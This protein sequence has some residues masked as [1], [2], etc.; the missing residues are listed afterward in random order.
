[1]TLLDAG[2]GEGSFLD[3]LA[4]CLGRSGFPDPT[5]LG[6]D[7]AVPG[8]KAAA[9]RLKN[10]A[11]C[12]ADIAQIPCAQNSFDVV[13]NI[14]S[15]ANYG[16]FSRVLKKGGIVLKVVPT[17]AHLAEIRVAL[18]GS[19]GFSNVRVVEHFGASVELVKSVVVESVIPCGQSAAA[20]L[21]PMTPLSWH[22]TPDQ[23]RLFLENAPEAL[24]VSFEVLVGRVF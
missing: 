17:T 3:V 10:H 21:F 2:S 4:T 22:A 14:L 9:G 7:L 24:T 13:L 15:P 1:L 23:K 5:C 8:V 11:W 16:E 19:E 18:H 6:I 20:V 12:V